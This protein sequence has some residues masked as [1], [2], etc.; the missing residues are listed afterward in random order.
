MKGHTLAAAFVLA[1]L[2][3]AADARAQNASD[4][5]AATSAALSLKLELG[6]SKLDSE[7]VRRAIELELKRAVVLAAAPDDAPSLTVVAHENR[8]V[9]VSYHSSSGETRARSIGV[10]EDR[11]RGAEVIA[12]LAGNLS[13]DEAAELLAKLGAKAT[14]PAG[15]SSTKPNELPA[16]GKEATPEP[17]TS[18]PPAPAKAAETRP[19]PSP[20][21]AQTSAPPP[22]LQTPFPAFNLTLLAP[23]AL[24]RHSERR[25]FAAELGL[26]YSHVGELHGAGLNLFALRTERDIRGFSFA[27]VYDYTGGMVSG[28][29]GSA[30]LNRRQRLRGFEFSG[31]V[32]LGTGDARGFSAAGLANLSGDVEGLQA[33]GL[34]NRSSQFQGLQAAGLVNRSSRFQGLQVA[35]LVNSANDVEGLQA[36]AI[37]NRAEGFSGVQAAGAVNLAHAISGLQVGVV[38]VAGDVHGVQLGVVNVAKHV[39]GTSVGLVSVAD[40]GRAQPVLW[41][42]SSQLLNAAAKFTVGPL[43]TQAGFGC[44]PNNQT[45]SYELGLGGHISVG[46]FFLEPGVHYSEMRSTRHPFDHELLEY[47]HFRVAAGMELGRVSPFAGVGLLQRFAHTGDAPA[48]V[49]LSLEVFGGA[50]LF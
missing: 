30:I 47:G 6:N 17:T 18:A 39:D 11:A 9:T 26:L 42:S 34:V 14:P 40:N 16:D 46:R 23:I 38:N 48:S 1:A 27:A 43:Y 32:N 25:I 7:S 10:P 31:L 50:A 20:K 44:A 8:T 12:L 45:F 35:G 36:A 19:P 21:H 29:T 37:L 24:Y 15:A 4:E 13:R 5:S 49:P 22:L 33:A 28:V 2:S 3:A 41:T